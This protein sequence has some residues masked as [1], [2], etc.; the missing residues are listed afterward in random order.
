MTI[1][2]DLVGGILLDDKARDDGDEGHGDCLEEAEN[3]IGETTDGLGDGHA[4]G[5]EADAVVC[6]DA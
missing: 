6:A 4:Y 2:L 1:A 3:A 5:G